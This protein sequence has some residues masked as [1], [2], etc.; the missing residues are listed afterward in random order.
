MCVIFTALF[1]F[2]KEANAHAF[3]YC[4]ENT[5]PGQ[6]T[7][8]LGSYHA[9]PPQGYIE[10]NDGSTTVTANF[11]S[12]TYAN[13]P[14]T[15]TTS[16][17]TY[18]PFSSYTSASVTGWQEATITG[19]TVATYSWRYVCSGCPATWTPV[20]GTEGNVNITSAL[21]GAVAITGSTP[22]DNATDVEITSDLTLQF[23][24]TVTADTGN[25]TLYRSS[26]N[27]VIETIAAN[28]ARVSGY[29]TS[30]LL[31]DW[32][33]N[34][35]PSTDYYVLIDNNAFLNGDG[36][37]SVD[38]FSNPTDLN[39]TT[40]SAPVLSSSTPVDN[41]ASVALAQNLILTFDQ[42]VNVST[43]SIHLY[44]V[45][46]PNALIESI[47]ANNGAR[48]S[49][50]GTNTI[51]IDWSSNLGGSTDYFINI[52]NNAFTNNNGTLN[53]AG[54]S[55]TTSLN[56]ST[57]LKPSLSS[58]TPS[59]DGSSVYLNSNLDLVFNENVVQGT[60]NIV[61]YKSSDNSVI[62]SLDVASSTRITGWSGST[63]T[64][65][66]TNDLDIAT[67]YYVQIDNNCH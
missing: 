24:D 32:T 55:D 54:I 27:S 16:D 57:I 12:T 26:D 36:S 53:Y 3:A 20:A 52:D 66:W 34:L 37:S 19:L 61:L 17:C 9:G 25:I 7:F 59:D 23:S 1:S 13:T 60:G 31:V 8:W 41:A 39:F 48:V 2:Q 67:D 18:I 65:D 33:S 58:S 64:V 47:A 29:G 30:T 21:L 49:G 4:L 63:L 46:T 22:M 10:L 45:D 50:S 42:V 28:G 35:N 40:R 43:G 5:G 14:S 56:F 51:T 44:K 38:G 11:T 6:V 62:E 15:L